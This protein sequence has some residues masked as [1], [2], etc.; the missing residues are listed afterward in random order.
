MTREPT[1]DAEGEKTFTCDKCDET[2]TE[3]I[4]KLEPEN[5]SSLVWI[6]LV[7]VLVIAAAIV[8]FFVLNKRKTR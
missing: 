2:K 3:A 7:I 8:I 5:G 1:V 4:E 6:I